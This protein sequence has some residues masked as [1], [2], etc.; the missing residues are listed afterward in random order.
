[1]KSLSNLSLEELKFI[2]EVLESEKLRN[3]L[4]QEIERK[5]HSTVDLRNYSSS[6]LPEFYEEYKEK[7]M[8]LLDELTYTDVSYLIMPA[9]TDYGNNYGIDF[10][11]HPDPTVAKIYRE[12]HNH[13]R[14]LDNLFEEKS[15]LIY[16]YEG[17]HNTLNYMKTYMSTMLNS[18]QNIETKADLFLDFEEKKKLITTNFKSIA[19]YLLHVRNQVP[20]SRLSVNNHVLV[21][22]ANKRSGNVTHRQSLFISAIAFGST[23]EKLKE[24]NY[25]EATR[26]LFVPQCKMLKK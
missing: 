2:K 15:S 19:E 3:E 11:Y 12:S 4:N 10:R 16:Y 6:R 22:N 21:K 24:E 17:I 9:I 23:L 1:M 25:E 14:I 7:C 26:L 8:K 5:T 13:I 20:N 18:G